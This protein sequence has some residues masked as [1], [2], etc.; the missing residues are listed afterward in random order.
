M[1]VGFFFIRKNAIDRP[2]GLIRLFRMDYS[3]TVHDTMDMCINSDIWH[4]IEYR[5][6]HFRC[7]DA[8]SRKI[9][10][11]RKII[12]E[13]TLI[14]SSKNRSNFLDIVRFISIKIHIFQVRLDG[15]ERKIHNI[16]RLSD[17]SKKWWR[18]FVHLF[19]GCLSRENNCTNQLKRRFIVKLDFLSTIKRDNFFDKGKWISPCN[20]HQVE[21]KH[22]SY[23]P[24]THWDLDT[25]I[26]YL[27]F[28]H[29]CRHMID[30]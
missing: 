16:T 14:I 30:V 29:R 19:I 20:F 3:D 22:A 12:R 2:I 27:V 28:S 9:L 10:D 4:I 6:K 15:F 24:Y 8:N 13:S 26:F 17:Y 7:L 1:H 23:L 25:K 18:N 11:S 21:G 5:E